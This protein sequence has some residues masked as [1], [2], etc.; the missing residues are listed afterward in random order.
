MLKTH[1]FPLVNRVC[2][3]TYV[4]PVI[5]PTT[6][7]YNK[8]TVSLLIFK[9]VFQSKTFFTRKSFNSDN[10]LV[11]ISGKPVVVK[12]EFK[13]ISFGEIQEVNMVSFLSS[14]HG[15]FNSKVKGARPKMINLAGATHLRDLEIAY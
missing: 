10:S 6:R 14:Y 1:Y 15:H 13:V 7:I 2:V 9:H 3:V 12:V 11:C 4:E 5:A 8:N